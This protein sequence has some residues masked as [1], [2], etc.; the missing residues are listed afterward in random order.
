MRIVQLS[1]SHHRGAPHRL[2]QALTSAG[3][4]CDLVCLEPSPIPCGGENPSWARCL[5]LIDQAQV[6]HL[7]GL[8]TYGLLEPELR[9]RPF[10]VQVH[11][12]GPPEVDLE[13]GLPL[14]V[15]S[16]A[17][18][19][20]FTDAELMPHV[21]MSAQLPRSAP[22]GSGPL[23]IFTSPTLPAEIRALYARFLEPVVAHLAPRVVHVAPVKESPPEQLA[24][25]RAS[26]H[27]SLQR[28][29]GDLDAE[30]L[31]AL[32]QGLVVVSGLSDVALARVAGLLGDHPP[33]ERA[34]QVAELGGLLVRLVQLALSNPVPFQRRRDRGPA[35]IRQR[36]DP[37][38]ATQRWINLYQATAGQQ[39]S[40]LREAG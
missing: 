33:L 17:L 38:M 12:P 5:E 32:A 27:I 20:R 21:I 28:L 9:G 4:D 34:N 7:H 15:A 26:C 36:C 11:N 39:T 30:T 23:R 35:F 22:L 16:P 40:Q 1:I 10:L 3:L 29:D 8:E 18:Q 24:Q 37:T 13:P 31:E 19:Q 25:L 14:V 6:V 2:H